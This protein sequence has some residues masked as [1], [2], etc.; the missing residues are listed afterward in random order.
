MEFKVH[1]L[2]LPQSLQS[3][4]VV[5]VTVVLLARQVAQAAVVVPTAVMLVALAR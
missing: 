4:A 3:V 1:L 2:F 5:A